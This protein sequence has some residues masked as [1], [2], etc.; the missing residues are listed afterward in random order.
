MMIKILVLIMLGI[1]FI[2]GCGPD[3]FTLGAMYLKTELGPYNIDE[4]VPMVGLEWDLKDKRSPHSTS[5][6]PRTVSSD[7]GDL[8]K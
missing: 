1:L 2:A 3:R 4:V 6:L 8:C 7:S 5:A